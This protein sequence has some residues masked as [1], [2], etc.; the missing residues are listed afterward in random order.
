MEKK[1]FD[2][3]VQAI[4]ETGAVLR[5]EVPPAREFTA[6]EVRK[7]AAQARARRR[8]RESREQSRGTSPARSRKAA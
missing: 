6:D 5:G 1:L 4:V 7:N 2:E 3:L 8:Q